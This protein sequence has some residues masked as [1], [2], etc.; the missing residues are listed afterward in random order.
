MDE[1]LIM[2]KAEVRAFDDRAINELGV[3]SAVLMENAGRGCAEVVAGMGE[4]E[5]SLKKAGIF[6]GT[7]NNGGDGFVIGR[8]LLNWGL[9]VE[10]V[11]CGNKE[12]ISGDALINLKILENIGADIKLIDVH[13]DQ[14]GEQVMAIMAEGKFDVVVDALFGTGL[15]GNIRSGYAEVIRSINSIE[16]PVVAVD[17]PSGLDCD[18]GLPFTGPDGDPLAVKADATVTFVAVKKGFYE[19]AESSEYTGEVFVASIGVE[20]N[21][22]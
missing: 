18:T 2:S 7:G 22:E 8:Q 21:Y 5:D 10:F 1:L 13:G 12:K 9:A 17:I 20:P 19:C 14:A 4:T 15:E 16:V 6:C 3:P 11:I